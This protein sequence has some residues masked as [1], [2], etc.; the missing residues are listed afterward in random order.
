[1]DLN[2]LIDKIGKMIKESGIAASLGI[3]L[4][5]SSLPKLDYFMNNILKSP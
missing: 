3:T 5:Q 4:Y 2:P 1:M